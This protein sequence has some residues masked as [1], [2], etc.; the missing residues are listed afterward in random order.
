MQ[1]VQEN[2]RRPSGEHRVERKGAAVAISF[3]NGLYAWLRETHH[4]SRP[5]LVKMRDCTTPLDLLDKVASY[6]SQ[7][8]NTSALAACD[9]GTR[10]RRLVHY[11]RFCLKLRGDAILSCV[12]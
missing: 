5:L 10:L 9:R 3:D 8:M 2:L 4:C 6:N 11:A 7:P 12:T 1:T